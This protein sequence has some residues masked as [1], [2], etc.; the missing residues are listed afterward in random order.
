M[1]RNLLKSLSRRRRAAVGARRPYCRSGQL[2]VEPLEPRRLLANASLVAFPFD[3]GVRDSNATD[4][5]VTTDMICGKFQVLLGDPNGIDD[6]SVAATD[7]TLKK[8]DS[9]LTLNTDY[10]WG[11]DADKDLVTFT[12]KDSVF[13]NEDYEIVMAQDSIKDGGGTNSIDDCDLDDKTF[14]ITVNCTDSEEF[15]TIAVMPDTQ[16]YTD[17]A[18]NTGGRE[19][20]PWFT[21]QTQ[22]IVDEARDENIVFA[23][24]LGDI[25]QN[26]EVDN[27]RNVD[28]W[29]Y[30][31]EAMIILDE[32]DPT[33]ATDYANGSIPYGACMGNHD[34]A[35]GGPSN[36][37]G[38]YY[39]TDYTD[40]APDPDEFH[41]GY[42]QNRYTQFD[43]QVPWYGGTPSSGGA[44]ADAED[45]YHYQ[46]IS[47]GSYEFLHFT[48]A[49][50][51]G[52]NEIADGIAWVKDVIDNQYPDLP[53]IISTHSYFE[54]DGT[55]TPEGTTVFNDLVSERP[56]IFMVLCGHRHSALNDVTY[57]DGNMPVYEILVDYQESHNDDF[58][59]GDGY[60]RLM[61][62]RPEQ[63]L[64]EHTTYSPEED[65]SM[66]ALDNE[67]DLFLDF[68]RRLSAFDAPVATLT[69]PEDFGAPLYQNSALHDLG[70][71]DL[72]PAA[73]T[74]LTHSAQTEFVIQLADYDPGDGANRFD[75]SNID[76]DSANL[77]GVVTMTKN[78]ES[79]GYTIDD[80]DET[81]NFYTIVPS[82]GPS[83]FGTG[84]YEITIN[85]GAN[86]VEDDDGNAMPTTTLTV[87]IDTG[88][89]ETTLVSNSSSDELVAKKS[90][91]K[92]L[93]DGSN[94]GTAWR[95]PSFDDDGWDSGNGILG[96]GGLRQRG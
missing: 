70:A 36:E 51:T 65:A 38:Y 90:S 57:N 11:Y 63:N 84:T 18:R 64:I 91:W 25:V 55:R 94:Q 68:E 31:D 83:E 88:I 23:T 79:V 45:L 86:K 77:A 56:Q 3:D 17:D 5:E 48:M 42:G 73:N 27:A 78:G 10:T 71:M 92:Y 6:T 61:K 47:A 2:R 49:F 16:Y 19:F 39:K 8:D 72:D 80:Y 87:V 62:F 44:Y 13:D 30:A 75:A 9:A 74:V 29:N 81:D 85:G 22:W 66:T 53:V 15:F 43:A 37:P 35:A 76:D 33:G 89:E 34:D 59:G 24:H 12:A 67:F 32:V 14:D 46:I 21:A 40:T 41:Y 20:L 1:L 58:H 69:T 52:T 54:T 82:G 95:N 60:M 7:F 26:D 93:D 96:Y 28:E 4:H 50:G